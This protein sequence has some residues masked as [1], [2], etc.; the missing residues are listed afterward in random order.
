GMSGMW[1]GRHRLRQCWRSVMPALCPGRKTCEE[2]APWTP[3]S[4]TVWRLHRVLKAAYWDV[5][6]RVTWGSEEALQ[7]L[8]PPKD[9]TSIAWA[10][11]VCNSAGPG[12]HPSAGEHCLFERPG[13]LP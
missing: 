12:S 4:L 7:A 11:A 5:H 8:P 10:L 9:G 6:L 2:L 1:Q 13:A 3:G